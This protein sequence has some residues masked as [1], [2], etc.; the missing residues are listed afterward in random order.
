MTNPLTDLETD[1]DQELEKAL[2][3][4]LAYASRQ[5][6]DEAEVK[7]FYQLHEEIMRRLVRSHTAA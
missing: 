3:R 5:A 7:I 1:T 4:V 6:L 2:A